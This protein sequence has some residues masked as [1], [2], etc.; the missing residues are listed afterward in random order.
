MHMLSVLSEISKAVWNKPVKCKLIY[1]QWQSHNSFSGSHTTVSVAVTQQFQWQSHNSFSD[2]HTT[3]SVTVTQQ[4][5]DSHTTVSVEIAGC[6]ITG[7]RKKHHNVIKHLINLILLVS[8]V[9]WLTCFEGRSLNGIIYC[10]V[11][12]CRIVFRCVCCQCLCH[13][14]Q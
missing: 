14:V 4:F 9:E 1:I 3:V 12:L 7:T 5:S 6:S 11:S 8:H 13:F 10:F 2:S